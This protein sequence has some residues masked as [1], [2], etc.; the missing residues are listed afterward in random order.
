M[1]FSIRGYYVIPSRNQFWGLDEWCRYVDCSY[2]DGCNFLILWIA[3][4]F[5]SRLYP[6][7]WQY[8]RLHRNIEQNFYP[9]LIDYAHKKGIRAV[10]GFT[11]Y[12]YDGV[13][14]FAAAHLDFAGRNADGSVHKTRGIHDVGMWLCP[15][16]PESREFMLNYV[17]EM[18]FEFH[19]NADGL[20]I[21]SSDYGHCQCPY[22]VDRYVE[23]EWQFVKQISEEVWSTK[24][25]ATVIIYPIYYQQGVATPDEHYTL[26]FTPHS[27]HITPEVLETRCRKIYWEGLSFEKLDVAARGAKIAHDYGL[28]GYVVA[29]EVFGYTQDWNGR[30]VTYE[31]FDVPWTAA[32]FPMEDL[33]PRVLRFS[34][35]FY[36]HN[37][38]ATEQE[39]RGAV[40]AYFFEDSDIEAADDL[41][42]LCSVLQE[43]FQHFGRRS[44]L[45]HP[46]DFDYQY[47]GEK[48][49]Q[50]LA[51]YTEALSR[52]Q[53]ISQ[54]H[55][56]HELGQ[57][58]Q[59]IVD[60]WHAIHPEVFAQ[61]VSRT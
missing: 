44:A 58:A 36:S 40:A 34:Y 46:E 28:D 21:E 41:L 59:W 23:R 26:F 49:S 31:P 39:F 24:A 55:A 43:S 1:S 56:S 29:M 18:F 11:P 16:Y 12:A 52:L 61:G 6:E 5:R 13:A 53:K 25:D 4:S 45:A 30:L 22:C 51:T 35:K 37:P 50:V 9:E 48:R 33:V 38:N 14:S 20:F 60:R 8:N 47:S 32:D 3:G 42:Y 17:R 7:T 19:P 57:V 54:R 2:E 27:A 15:N 10:L